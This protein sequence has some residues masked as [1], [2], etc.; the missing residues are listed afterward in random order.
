[1]LEA[2][3]SN[4][5]ELFA[6]MRASRF[7][8]E[9]FAFSLRQLIVERVPELW[10]LS[11]LELNPLGIVLAFVGLAAMIARRTTIGVLLTL[12][13]GGILFLTLNVGAT[14][15]AG[16]LIPA[17]VLTWIVVGIGLGWLSDRAAAMVRHG[18][19]AAIVAAVVLPSI[20]LARNYRANDHH[21]RTYEIRY[22]D[23]LF[24]R[25]EARSAL[26]TESY[27]VDQLVLYKL[28]GE[29]ADRGR[30]IGLIT[31]DVETVRQHA[32]SGFATYAFSAGRTALESHG[33]RFEPVQLAAMGTP[34]SAPIDM[35]PL[36]LFRLTKVTSC[37]DIGNS[38]W[39]D[40]TEVARDGRL[41]IRI[42]KYRPFDS[43]VVLYV[44][45]RSA[46]PSPLLAA[47]Q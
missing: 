25:L 10:H 40:I 15:V 4:L 12:G 31:R 1:Y 27:A 44:A 5:R 6:V 17:F 36:P 14:D 3:A 22:F 21:L 32:S 8:D 9:I 39:Q 20:Q 23:A 45:Q 7:S 18:A 43:V 42:D 16:F 38:G 2:R 47:S 26:V 37:Q 34:S 46:V 24:D 41:L 33:F 19:V 29:H 13:A 28:A 35:S 30:T 11:V